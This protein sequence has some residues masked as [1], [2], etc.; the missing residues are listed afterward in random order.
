MPSNFLE[1]YKETQEE[2]E[3]GERERKKGKR[4]STGGLG[5]EIFAASEQDMEQAKRIIEEV[6][7]FLSIL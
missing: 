5:M 4:R 6:S 2:D 3:K 7:S 1:E